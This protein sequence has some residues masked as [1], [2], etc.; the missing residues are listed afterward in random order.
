LYFL[1]FVGLYT[2][3]SVVKKD[4]E[5]VCTIIHESPRFKNF[6]SEIKLFQVDRR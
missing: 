3:G 1:F 5:T 4:K 2:A 6:E